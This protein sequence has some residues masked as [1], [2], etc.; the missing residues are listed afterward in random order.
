MTLFEIK[1]LNVYL[2][3]FSWLS[4]WKPYDSSFFLGG[5]EHN[6]MIIPLFSYPVFVKKGAYIPLMHLGEDN[7]PEFTWFRPSNDSMASSMFRE[8]NGPGMIS[9]ANVYKVII[10]KL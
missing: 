7:I 3:Y 5:T 10:L 9:K 6:K 2:S 1:Y 4:W 8:R